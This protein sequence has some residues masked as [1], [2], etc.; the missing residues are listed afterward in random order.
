MRVTQDEMRQNFQKLN[1][2][3]L[4]KFDQIEHIK[5]TTRNLITYHKYYGPI[6]TQHL[7][8]ESMNHLQAAL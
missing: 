8:S 1:E 4:I 3:L 6:E 5:Q 2:V 7:I